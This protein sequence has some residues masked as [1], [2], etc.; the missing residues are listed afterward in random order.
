MKNRHLR[1][2]TAVLMLLLAFALTACGSG[3]YSDSRMDIGGENFDGSYKNEELLKNEGALGGDG[4]V[5]DQTAKIIKNVTLR[6]ETKDFDTA[7][8]TLKKQVNEQGGYIESSE[9]SGG[10]SYRNGYE[11]E[12]IASYVIRIPADKL[13]S[14]LTKAKGV[15]NVVSSSESTEDVTLDYY[16]IESRLN[17]LKSKKA[18]L[19]NMLSKAET[20]DD[21]LTIQE[22]LYD[23]IADIEA[24]QSKL[25]LYDNK[26]SYSTVRLTVNEVVEYTETEL[27]FGD[28][29]SKAFKGG[30]EW[31]AEA[32]QDIAIVLVYL[33]PLLFVLL[34][35]GIVWLTI[36]F[37]RKKKK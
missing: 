27:S 12:R 31:F 9:I 35:G 13:D 32:G 28:R 7:T 10:K 37:I 36:H 30:W 26:V 4:E 34:V 22:N 2:L 3:E 24:Y 23:V 25:N 20:L 8:E 6:G 33:L 19:E 1:L 11:G 21:M 18:A 5:Q 15:L 16:D 14:F 17:T 29:L